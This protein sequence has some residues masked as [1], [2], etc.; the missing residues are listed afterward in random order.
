[1]LSLFHL[2]GMTLDTIIEQARQALGFTSLNNM[3]KAVL[4]QWGNNTG[5][6]VVYSPTGTGKTLATAIPALL[7]T[8]P[9][10]TS[11][12]VVIISPSRELAI[13]THTVI[14][15]VSPLTLVTCCYGGHSS[16]DEQLALAS[17]PQIVV[18]TPGRLLDHINKQ[19]IN[20]SGITCMVLDEFDKSLE[21]GFHDEMRSILR[22]CP[23]N[24]RKILTSATVID[25]MPDFV[26]LN[27]CHTINMLASQGLI[28]DN[29]LTLWRVSTNGNTP[30]DTLQELLYSITDERTIVF[31]NTRE[32]AQQVYDF[33]S[34]KKMS[35]VL[36]HGT[37]EQ[38]E[39]EK[40]LAM[41][42]NGTA[43]VL[44]ATDLAARGLDIA[45]VKH[46]IHYELPLTGEIFTHR[47]GRTARVDAT[48][49]AYLITLTDALLPHYAKACK[50]FTLNSNS[51][52]PKTSSISTLYISAGK[53]EKVSRG[54]IV[55]FLATNAPSLNASEI[56]RIDIHDHYALVAVPTSK[57]KEII[58]SVSPFKLKKQKVKLSVAKPQLRFVNR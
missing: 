21:L 35:T 46:I 38:I 29:R 56:G 18:G 25:K 5:D 4:E 48:G 47:N 27:N 55:G 24:A 22:H 1:M 30:L 13:Q 31:A 16:A 26:R 28:V 14:K 39:R 40:A 52:N 19:H 50:G 57:T 3:Q 7:A 58:K 43:M 53:K 12:Q 41:F 6:L 45:D 34:K 17:G 54:D 23:T 10:F 36:Y 32:S 42:N 2:S 37:L 20:L 9:E 15:K 49:E 44:V 33:L 11:P 8:N 51:R